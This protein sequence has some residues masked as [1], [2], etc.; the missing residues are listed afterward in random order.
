[1][2]RSE[3]SVAEFVPGAAGISSADKPSAGLATQKVQTVS[4]KNRSRDS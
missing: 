3:K 4:G 1:M 2:K